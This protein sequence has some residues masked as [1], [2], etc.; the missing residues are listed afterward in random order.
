MP[1]MPPEPVF[2]LLLAGG[3][4]RRM[5]GGDKCLQPIA[6]RPMLEHV[7]A[8][9]RPQTAALVINAG[10][11]ESRFADFGLPVVADVIDGFAGPLAGVLTGMLWAR[12]NVPQC[13]WIVSIATDTPLLPSDLVTRFLAATDRDDTDLVCASSGG[14]AHPVFGLWPVRLAEDLRSALV[15]EGM[16]KIDEWTAR[17]RLTTVSFDDAPFD[18]FFNVN[19]PADLETATRLTDFGAPE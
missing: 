3:Q 13:R 18:P 1:S 9:A 7:I 11:D 2:G 4:A 16:R 5:G 8:R 12:D 19:T 17:Y 10:G 14:R 15:D 6:G